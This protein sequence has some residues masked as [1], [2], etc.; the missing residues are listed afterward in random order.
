[1]SAGEHPRR[2]GGGGRALIAAELGGYLALRTAAAACGLMPE[3]VARHL[4]ESLGY[5]SSYVLPTRL[6][7]AR[8]HM[9]RVMGSH[10]NVRRAAR[11]C[12]ATYGRYWAETFWIRPWRMAE[13]LEHVTVEGLEHLTTATQQGRGAVLAMTHIGNFEVCSLVAQRLGLRSLGVAEA[14]ANRYIASWF[15]RFRRSMGTEILLTDHADW[16][17]LVDHLAAGGVVGLMADRDVTRTG[18]EVTFFG[19]AT[20]LPYGPVALSLRTGAPL[21]PVAAYFRTGRGHRVVI[22]APVPLPADGPRR[23]RIEQGT[24][25][26]ATV[27][28]DLIRAAP[29]QWHLLQPNWPSDP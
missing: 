3:A 20:R 12:F 17:C 16:R 11:Q 15:L 8:R 27:L 9:Q 24:Q 13:M 25:L 19:E 28:E 26:L 1:M 23:R 22:G 6:A 21:L 29:T 14:L 4:G 2:E 5:L 18:I 7:R 10:W